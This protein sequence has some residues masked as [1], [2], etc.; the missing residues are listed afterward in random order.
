MKIELFAM[1]SSCKQQTIELETGLK[2]VMRT[3]VRKVRIVPQSY[4]KTII[5]FKK[6]VTVFNIYHKS[7]HKRISYSQRV[8]RDVLTL[9]TLNQL[10]QKDL[11]LDN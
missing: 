8:N 10:I 2:V 11:L 3:R 5:C 7:P 6:L 9:L 4:Q 1:I